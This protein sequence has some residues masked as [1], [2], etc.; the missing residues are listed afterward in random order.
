MVVGLLTDKCSA[1]EKQLAHDKTLVLQQQSKV[2]CKS[3]C[4]MSLICW[5]CSVPN[6]WFELTLLLDIS[7]TAI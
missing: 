4:K 6:S 7:V 1:L 3:A 5:G 2:N